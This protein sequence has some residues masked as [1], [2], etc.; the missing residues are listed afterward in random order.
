MTL[1]IKE[2][3]IGNTNLPKIELKAGEI[4]RMQFSNIENYNN[5]LSKINTSFF[6]REVINVQ[7]WAEKDENIVFVEDWF[8]RHAK[9]DSFIKEMNLTG[10]EKFHELPKPY[11]TIV[12][13]KH[14]L[15]N[16]IHPIVIGTAGMHIFNLTQTYGLLNSFLKNGGVCI[17][18]TYPTMADNEFIDVL[19]VV[20]N[21]I[22]I[23]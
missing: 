3:Q 15:E 23:K 16:E 2:M 13:L 6:D 4:L 18:I 10:Q 17:E 9:K 8:N 5:I 1:K 7:L 11:K 12:C 21:V 20:P 22:T 14:I 19:G